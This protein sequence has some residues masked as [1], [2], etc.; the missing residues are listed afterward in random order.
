MSL[1]IIKT[2]GK[3]YIVSAGDEVKIEKIKDKKQGDQVIFDEVLLVQNKEK[4]E[5][6]K[7][8]VK[9]AKVTGEITQQDKDKKITILKYKSKTRYKVKKGHR[10]EYMKVKIEKIDTE[11]INNEQQT[12]NNKK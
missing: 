12:V 4:L 6:G 5:I 10:Q 2:G 7:P 1:A 11:T 9:N 3:Q 8:F